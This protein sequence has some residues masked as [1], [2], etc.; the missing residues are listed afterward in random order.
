MRLAGQAG[1]CGVIAV[2][3][4]ALGVGYGLTAFVAGVGLTL[5]GGLVVAHDRH[6]VHDERDSTP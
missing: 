5:A 2:L 6:P 1:A 4:F 3:L